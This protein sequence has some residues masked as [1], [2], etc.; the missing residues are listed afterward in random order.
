MKGNI[1]C[2][3]IAFYLFHLVYPLQCPC[4]KATE[5]CV[6]NNCLKIN[7]GEISC[8]GIG[9]C[10]DQ[11]NGNCINGLCKCQDPRVW[12]V[13]YEKCLIPNDG[14]T[15]AAFI[16][17]CMYQ[18]RGKIV[19]SACV[20]SQG[21]W[22]QEILS[23]GVKHSASCNEIT[24]FCFDMTR[25]DCRTGKCECKDGY[26]FKLVNGIHTCKAENTNMMPCTSLYQ[27]FSDNSMADCINNKCTCKS[28]AIYSSYYGKCGKP[29]NGQVSCTNED[30]CLSN[31]ARHGA[32]SGT[33]ICTNGYMWDE[34]AGECLA[35]NNGEFSCAFI[36][37]CYGFLKGGASCNG[38]TKKCSCL[39]GSSKMLTD[40][41]CLKFNDN[42]NSCTSISECYD[43]GV[44]AGCLLNKC[45]CQENYMLDVS[46]KFCLGKNNALSNCMVIQNCIDKTSNAACKNN[47][48]TCQSNNVWSE[49]RK[50]CAYPNTK[51]N[52]A[53]SLDQCVD[54]RPMFA[55]IYIGLCSC[56]AGYSWLLVKGSY[57]CRGDIGMA[58]SNLEN[59]CMSISEVTSECT[60][61][62]Q[63]KNGY[64]LNSDQHK[65]LAYNNGET[66][67]STINDCYDFAGP[68]AECSALNK[69]DCIAN[70]EWNLEDKICQGKNNGL[71][72]CSGNK[73][74]LDHS[75][76]AKCISGFCTCK[77]GMV[78]SDT[79]KKCTCTYG[80]YMAAAGTCELC[81]Q[82]FYKNEISD[83]ECIP[84][85]A[86]SESQAGAAICKCN[87]GFYYDSSFK[88]NECQRIFVCNL[89]I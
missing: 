80:N 9:E 82:N 49:Y 59:D 2:F 10:A 73:T 35:P 47:I 27:C 86:N 65:C 12:S 64:I 57:L 36:Y 23:C 55:E 34:D 76:R 24:E 28:G 68:N 44:T 40:K 89:K 7:T 66:Y 8:S 4:S 77:V 83:N 69:C 13:M 14:I 33:C 6:N 63:C 11:I 3:I 84:C 74:C 72:K 70:S 60:G 58:C 26:R 19:S 32:C 48:C 41:I 75:A 16:S 79:D 39:G 1:T 81:K 43:Q 21:T 71:G 17:D 52:A 51:L 29:N 37:D 88:S 15:P 18:I 42:K 20:C 67:C 50:L 54:N 53:A 25:G 61:T 38:G 87:P 22:T 78:W 85:P 5:V 46:S 45:T 56:K 31:S 30:E 62:C